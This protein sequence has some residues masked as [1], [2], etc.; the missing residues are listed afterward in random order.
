MIYCGEP[1]CT[2]RRRSWTNEISSLGICCSS[3]FSSKRLMFLAVERDWSAAA[4]GCARTSRKVSGG[5]NGAL[6]RRALIDAS[7]DHDPWSTALLSANGRNQLESVAGGGAAASDPRDECA[8]LCPRQGDGIFAAVAAL[9]SASQRIGG[10]G[11]PR[12]RHSRFQLRRRRASASDSRLPVTQTLWSG[13]DFTSCRFP[14]GVSG[15]RFGISTGGARRGA[16]SRQALC[17][18]LSFLPRAS[19]VCT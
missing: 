5:G 19:F 9:P 15:K 18:S 3:E 6:V 8:W 17:P 11:G 4:P 10:V 7:G 2:D 16:P 12:S 14:E 13:N 1:H